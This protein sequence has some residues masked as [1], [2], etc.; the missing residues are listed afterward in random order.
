MNAHFAEVLA[1]ETTSLAAVVDPATLDDW[2]HRLVDE[3]L[4]PQSPYAKVLRQEGDLDD[5]AAFLDRWRALIAATVARVLA[6]DPVAR[7][8]TDVQRTALLILAAL[9]GGNILSRVAKDAAPLNAALDLALVPLI[10][11]LDE[12][13]AC[14]GRNG[15][16]GNMD[17]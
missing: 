9:H 4:A 12:A 1:R 11:T 7:P 17:A 13:P 8:K 14:T 15:P 5:R 6:S 16:L 10:A 3:V 2:R